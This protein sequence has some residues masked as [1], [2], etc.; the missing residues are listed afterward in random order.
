MLPRST[1][2]RM[3]REAS[4]GKQGGRT[5]EIRSLLGVRYVPQSI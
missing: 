4:T 3:T 5:I 2:E 1:G